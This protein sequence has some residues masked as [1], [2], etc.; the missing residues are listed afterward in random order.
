MISF[1]QLGKMGRLGN[2]FFQVAAVIGTAKRNNLDYVIPKWSVNEF[3]STPVPEKDYFFP[4]VTHAE[5]YCTYD[6]ISL[7]LEEGETL[8]VDL[9]G[10]FQ[11]EKYF[12]DNADLV[13]SHFSPSVEMSHSI[14]EKY[15][16]LFQEKDIAS[17]HVR[18]GDY[19]SLTDVY[20]PTSLDYYEKCLKICKP[21]KVLVF[22][23]DIKSCKD[24]FGVR[25]NFLYVTERTH[26]PT[27]IS[28]T[29]AA[30]M[31]SRRYIE[32]DLTE[33]FLMSLCRFN[34]ITNSSYSWWAA[35]LNERQDKEVFAPTS[36]FEPNH[37]K[38]ICDPN[39]LDVYINDIIPESWKKM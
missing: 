29:A 17:L 18:R 23:D 36:W 20:T 4:Q 2:Q 6:P 16:F 8:D 38:R 27:V 35:W 34:I 9:K 13:R 3:L 22:S 39:K 24:V 31:D 1:A 28:T 32:Q 33:L 30:E 11:S 37:L 10:Y 12:I 21:K 7:E 14:Q 15:G 5:K 19:L 26:D 25:E